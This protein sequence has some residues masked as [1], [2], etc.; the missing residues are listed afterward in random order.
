[1]GCRYPLTDNVGTRRRRRLPGAAALLIGLIAGG[2]TA[3]CG[4]SSGTAAGTTSAAS[5]ASASSASAGNPCPAGAPAGTISETGSTL[6]QPLM[7][8]WAIAYH[9]QFPAATVTVTGGGS[10]QGINDASSGKCDIG[11]SD[12]YLSTGDLLKNPGL[13]NIP[14]AVSAQSVIFNLP[15][16][17]GDRIHLNGK[18][19][20]GMYDGSI[21]TWNDSAIKALNPG[22]SLPLTPVRPLHRSTGSGDT[23]IFTSY[24]STQD[25]GWSSMVGYGTLVNWPPL[26]VTQNPISSSTDMITQCAQTPGCV[27]YN[28]VSYLSQ[29]QNP[30]Y[31]LGEAALENSGGQYTT[32]DANQGAAITAELGYFVPITPDNETISMIAGPGDTGYPIINFE[33]AIVSMKQPTAAKA[34][35]VSHFLKWVVSNQSALS[36]VGSVGFQPLPP[37]IER[38]SLAQIARI[39]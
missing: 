31:H 35:Q 17:Q 11:A 18:V 28:G 2:L 21:K 19:L 33:Y 26:P 30:Q 25:Q 29:E 22:L 16:L 5:N 7:Q 4:T 37:D 39:H 8:K 24:L 34:K 15:S 9:Q 32:P 36:L 23:F 12:A 6:L 38:L 27:G 3:A 13:L 10:T 14:L 20:A 1:M